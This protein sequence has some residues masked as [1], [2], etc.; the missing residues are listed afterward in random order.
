MARAAAVG[1]LSCPICDFPEAEVRQ[2]KNGH[3]YLFCPDCNAQIF[4]RGCQVKERGLRMKMRPVAV[5]VAAAVEE[6]EEG[7]PVVDPEDLPTALPSPKPE[8]RR[9]IL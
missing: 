7:G 5:A 4:T 6:I 3:L 8:K 9:L 1:M 2:D